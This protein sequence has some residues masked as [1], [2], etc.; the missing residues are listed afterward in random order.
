MALPSAMTSSV[1]LKP[2][3]IA[4]DPAYIQL[5]NVYIQH[6]FCTQTGPGNVLKQ[7]HEVYSLAYWLT[8]HRP[9]ENDGKDHR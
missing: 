9:T 6:I 1:P 4:G 2:C 5:C 3:R 8:L 7:S